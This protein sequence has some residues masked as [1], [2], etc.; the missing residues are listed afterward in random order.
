MTI[1]FR[2]NNFETGDPIIEDEDVIKYQ[3][4]EEDLNSSPSPPPP[5]QLEAETMN[6]NENE[7]DDELQLDYVKKPT[8]LDVISQT[9]ED[10]EEVSEK[11]CH[12]FRSTLL[13]DYFRVTFDHF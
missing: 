1:Y 10:D 9:P 4:V 5:P 11:V 12:R 13:D 7:R 8:E 2:S 6:E 3:L